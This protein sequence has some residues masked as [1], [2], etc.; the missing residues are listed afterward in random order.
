[1]T[2]WKDVGRYGSVGIEL[3]VWM[4]L[5]YYGGRALDARVGA[6]GWFTFLGFVVGIGIG[7]RSIFKTA[8]HMRREFQKDDK[9]VDYPPGPPEKPSEETRKSE[10]DD[11]ELKP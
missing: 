11:H 5:G 6:G 8:E 2:P 1:M 9:N 7:F 10:H 4:A 3:L